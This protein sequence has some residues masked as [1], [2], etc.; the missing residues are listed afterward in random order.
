MK[1]L[2]DAFAQYARLPSPRIERVDLNALTRR[3]CICMRAAFPSSVDLAPNLPP[4]A[5]DPAL[6]RQVLVNLMKNAQEAQQNDQAS[7]RIRVD[8]RWKVRI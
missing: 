8:T 6:L 1:G 5:G 4:V 7:P 2:V 3:C